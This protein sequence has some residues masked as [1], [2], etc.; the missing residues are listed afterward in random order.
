MAGKDTLPEIYRPLMKAPSVTAP[1]CVVCGATD[2]LNQHHVVWRS[3]GN[4]FDQWG[5]KAKKP[6]VTLCGAGNASGCHKKAH[7]RKLHFRYVEHDFMPPRGSVNMNGSVMVMGTKGGHLEF[8]ETD[9]TDY[10]TALE[11]RGW[12]HIK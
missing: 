2:G 5:R 8:L 7:D 12:Q 6:T 4:L 10:A 9:T 3:W 1:H 11:E